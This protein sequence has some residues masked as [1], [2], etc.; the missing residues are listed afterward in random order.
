MRPCRLRER[1]GRFA[2]L[3]GFHHPPCG[4]RLAQ[5]ATELRAQRCGRSIERRESALALAG[6]PT[7]H[8]IKAPRRYVPGMNVTA[9]QQVGAPHNRVAFFLKRAV[10]EPDPGKQTEHQLLH[11]TLPAPGMRDAPLPKQRAALE[12]CRLSPLANTDL[13]NG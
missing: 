2:M 7:N 5:H 3:D 8:T 9:P 6:R 4:L 10:Q 11:A 12:S 1:D 13:A